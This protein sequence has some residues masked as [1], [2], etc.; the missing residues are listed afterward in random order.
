MELIEYVRPVVAAFY[1]AVAIL[2]IAGM[3]GRKAGLKRT[4][5]CLAAVGFTLHTVALAGR[6]AELGSE[7]FSQGPFYLSL[8]S[9]AL[10]LTFFVVRR[11]MRMEFLALT[12]A[13][14]AL[15][16]FLVSLAFSSKVILPK[17]LA[18]PFL[19]LHIGSLFVSIALLAMAFGAGAIFIQLER[20]IKTKEKL[21]DFNKDLPS[22]AA[23][24]TANHWSVVIGFPL[25]TLGLI[26]GFVWGHFTWGKAITWDPKEVVSVVIWLLYA[27]LFHQ[28]LTAGWRGRKAALLAILVFVFSL[29]S[30]AGVNFLLPTHHSFRP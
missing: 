12:T 4:A 8:L 2:F 29:V 11:T 13:P 25:F 3:L 23:F 14:L 5:S 20:K 26:T 18:G 28:R 16:L 10:L 22:L 30:L 1:L 27:Y 6:V 19:A 24:D 15:I 9:W 17:A 21:S 7:A